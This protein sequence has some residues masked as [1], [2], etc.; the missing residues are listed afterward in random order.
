M[1]NEK[2]VK[3]VEHWKKEGL[4]I[5]LPN[6]EQ[7]IIDCFQKIKKPI[8]EDVLEFY[9]FTG[10]TS[11]G[12]MDLELFS[13]WTLEEIIKENSSLK[14]ELALF[15]DYS[16]FLFCYGFKYENPEISSVYIEW[17]DHSPT[18]IAD[19]VEEFFDIYLRNPNE[20]FR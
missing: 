3:V 12:R 20:L 9:M 2:L 13:F 4:E 8:S 11:E 17:F 16:I 14:S 6:S 19:T 15:A 1:L 10:G 18:R 7:E 5:S